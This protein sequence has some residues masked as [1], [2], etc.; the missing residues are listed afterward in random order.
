M[1]LKQFNLLIK[2][3]MRDILFYENTDTANQ[4]SRIFEEFISSK[5]FMQLKEGISD[6]NDA[7]YCKKSL[8]KNLR[9]IA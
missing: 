4:L 7:L 6:S 3:S 5:P 1:K 9:G 2:T 8:K